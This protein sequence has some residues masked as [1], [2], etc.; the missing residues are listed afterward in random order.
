L[1]DYIKNVILDDDGLVL[2]IMKKDMVQMLLENHY[3]GQNNG[4]KLWALM[5]LNLWYDKFFENGENIE[6]LAR[7]KY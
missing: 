7:K 4:K 2:Q 1:K 3:D 5:V 6:I